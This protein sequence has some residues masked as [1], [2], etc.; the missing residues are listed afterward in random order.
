[1]ITSLEGTWLK[2]AFVAFLAVAG[3]GD[4]ALAQDPDTSSLTGTGFNKASTNAFPAHIA[5]PVNPAGKPEAAEAAS[6]PETAKLRGFHQAA[7]ASRTHSPA[8]IQHS[9]IDRERQQVDPAGR[10]R[11]HGN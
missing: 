9:R 5:K 8:D 10:R 11:D 3:P 6:A 2:I 7:G 4:A 1:M